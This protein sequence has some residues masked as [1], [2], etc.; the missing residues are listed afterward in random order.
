M[1]YNVHVS[2]GYFQGIDLG[3]VDVIN[4]KEASIKIEKMLKPGIKKE[5]IELRKV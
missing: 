2:T 1:L 4:R 3:N 5:N